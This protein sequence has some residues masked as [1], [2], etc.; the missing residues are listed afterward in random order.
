MELSY[1]THYKK[2]QEAY[3]QKALSF[4]SAISLDDIG[5]QVI[6]TNPAEGDGLI[7]LPGN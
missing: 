6:E 7:E 2:A 5:V 4:S 3:L 1:Q